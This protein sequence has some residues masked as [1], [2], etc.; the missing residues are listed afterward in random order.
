[1]WQMPMVW[2]V[3]WKRLGKGTQHSMQTRVGIRKFIARQSQTLTL[4]AVAWPCDAHPCRR[5]QLQC[6]A[7]V[8]IR[9]SVCF[10]QNDQMVR[11]RR[12]A[13]CAAIIRTTIEGNGLHN[14]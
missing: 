8:S 10:L 9:P 13:E 1:M 5:L 7:T 11:W 3:S 2:G 14:R 6:Q 4:K 12:G